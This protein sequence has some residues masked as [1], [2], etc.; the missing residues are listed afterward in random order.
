M[1]LAQSGARDIAELGYG[2]VL[3]AL[4]EIM[5]VGEWMSIDC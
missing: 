1:K 3:C 2:S 4:R 5:L